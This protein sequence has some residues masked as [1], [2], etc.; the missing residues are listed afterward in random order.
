M[1]KGH[2]WSVSLGM[3]KD[4]RGGEEFTAKFEVRGSKG[5]G[6]SKDGKFMRC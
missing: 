4:E 3:K 1:K 2:I 6:Q 5:E